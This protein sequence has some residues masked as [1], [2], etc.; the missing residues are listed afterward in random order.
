LQIHRAPHCFSDLLFNGALKDK[1]RS[2]YMGIIQ[3]LP[4]AQKTDAYQ[5]NG[6]LILDQAA[7]ADSIPGLEIEADDVR[8]THGATAAQ[9]EEEYVFYLMA[10]GLSRAAGR[11]H[12]RAGLL[13]GRA[14]P[15]AGGERRSQVGARDRT[16]DRRLSRCVCERRF[17]SKVGD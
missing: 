10:R 7:R 17:I 9:V 5:R 3:V 14:R 6:N 1:S 11:A 2:V 13:P 12:D 15:R 16:Q 4:G 8:C